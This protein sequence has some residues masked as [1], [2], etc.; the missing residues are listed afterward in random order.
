VNRKIKFL[1]FFLFILS[2]EKTVAETSVTVKIM[3]WNLLNY[4]STSG[5]S[6]DTALRHPFYRTV[7]QYENPDILVT[8]E[9]TFASATT[10][11]LNNVMNANGTVYAKGTFIDGPDTNNE[12]YFKSSDFAFISNTPVA[13]ALRDISE[14]KLKHI[15]TGDTIRVYAVHLKAS[16]GSPNDSLRSAEVDSLRKVTNALSPGSNF[17]VCGDFNFYGNYEPGYQK[18]L[19]NN[20]TDDGNFVDPI[21]MTGTWNYYPYRAYHTQSTRTASFGGGATGGMNDRFD[22]MLFSTAISQGTSG[23]VYV[24]GSTTPV[25][26]DGNH[27]NAAINVMPNAAAPSNVI[28]ALYNASDHLP[29]FAL[30]NFSSAN[31]IEALENNSVGLFVSPN[32]AH[33]HAFLKYTLNAPSY[34]SIKI[35]TVFGE[36]VA[37]SFREYELPGEHTIALEGVKN[38]DPGIYF[39]TFQSRN[40]FHT[41]KFIKN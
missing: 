21:T 2:V 14:F 8:E 27:F 29:V 6:A 24:P 26:N 36:E 9:N 4:P 12:I 3:C 38:F 19:H 39:I 5:A 15:A 32:P 41:S 16:S 28:D 31:S 20:S 34:I 25:G 30:F 11:F 37:T 33:D 13:T 7:I 1:L 17:I 10:W 23:I 35:F 18:L 40:S 22:M